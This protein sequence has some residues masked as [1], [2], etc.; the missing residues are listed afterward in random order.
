MDA[1]LLRR[2]EEE[3]RPGT[4]RVVVR[5]IE[6]WLAQLPDEQS[7]TIT[8]GAT[9]LLFPATAIVVGLCLRR[10]CC[11]GAYLRRSGGVLV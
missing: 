2:L 11:P 10:L 4:L 9:L 1:L 5:S 6:E 8:T 3:D 7:A